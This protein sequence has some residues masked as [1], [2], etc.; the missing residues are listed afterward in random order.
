MSSHCSGC[1]IWGRGSLREEKKEILGTAGGVRAGEPWV[2]D[3]APN[4]TSS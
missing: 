3:L 2:C 4:F 1:A